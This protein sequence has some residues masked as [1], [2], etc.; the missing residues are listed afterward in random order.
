MLDV[1]KK[2]TAAR[3]TAAGR[4]AR[5]EVV[6]T[7]GQMGAQIA[8]TAAAAAGERVRCAVAG[9]ITAAVR[10]NHRTA[11]VSTVSVWDH[12]EIDSDDLGDDN[13]PVS[14][15]EPGASEAVH[16]W[17]RASRVASRALTVAAGAAVSVPGG[18]LVAAGL[19]AAAALAGLA[20]RAA[21][22]V[23]VNTNT[24]NN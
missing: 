23:P 20:A 13:A 2:F 17:A 1:L 22:D 12:A 24:D 16:R 19:G 15:P 8:D 11:P 9:A 5:R 18:R 21:E 6:A 4:E 10:G 14:A 7:A 3:L